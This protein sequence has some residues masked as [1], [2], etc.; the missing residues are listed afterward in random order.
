MT[1]QLNA[2]L[3]QSRQR[4]QAIIEEYETG[5]AEIRGIQ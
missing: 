5:Q 2:E 4:M 1:Q 3:E